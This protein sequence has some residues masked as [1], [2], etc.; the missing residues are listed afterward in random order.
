MTHSQSDP[1]RYS[2]TS[3]FKALAS[4]G[5]VALVLGTAACGKSDD[6]RTAG[7][8]VDSA[9]AK[10]EQAAAEAK[11][12]AESG[13]A[14]AGDAMKDAAGKAEATGQSTTAKLGQQAN[15]LTITASVK[16]R[17]AKE[18]D[19]NATGINVDTSNGVVTL[20]GSAPSETAREK[21]GTIAKG[22]KGVGSVDNKLVIKPR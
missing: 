1:R 8:K 15:D 18:P 3:V 7:Q 13:M 6:G 4:A 2:G 5:A 12:R 10:T 19:L 14:K 22:V 9:I 17:L 11:A 21:A 20:S 16:A